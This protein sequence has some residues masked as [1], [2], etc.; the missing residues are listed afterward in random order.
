MAEKIQEAMDIGAE[1]G[2]RHLN[3]VNLK[4]LSQVPS[5]LRS[6]NTHR[7]PPFL[8]RGNL[9]MTPCP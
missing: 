8:A 1:F 2:A 3:F 9:N 6:A 5:R 7:S 4:Y